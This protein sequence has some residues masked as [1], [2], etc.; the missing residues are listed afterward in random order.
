MK[1]RNNFFRYLT[2]IFSSAVYLNQL[3]V[4]SAVSDAETVTI[5]SDVYEVDVGDG[6]TA[7]HIKVDVSAGGTKATGT[8][9][10]DNTAPSDGETVTI[11]SKVYTF[12]TTLTPLEGEVLIN[13]TADAALLNLIRAINHSGTP[14]TDYQCAV[15]NPSVTAATSVTSHTFA[16][17]AIYTGLGGNSIAT[18]ET[19]AHLSWGATTLASAADPTAAQFIAAFVISVNAAGK[20]YT[21][22][23]I[24]GGVLVY[25]G[26]GVASS[27]LT[28]TETLAGS[29]NAWGAAAFYGGK[30]PAS[31][32]PKQVW[33]TRV[34]TATEVALTLMQVVV[35]F[36]PTV[37]T[38]D[39]VVTATG[40]RTAWDGA[41]TISGSIITLD[42]SVGSTHWATTSTVRIRAME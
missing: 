29:N 33:L 22:L 8:L 9:T 2:R 38:V 12:K 20:A 15:A 19:S 24:T 25:T 30:A 3:R 7:G 26:S 23:G 36:T 11:G 31:K 18:T 41:I 14:G 37:V 35:P 27:A 32:P 10:S 21:A 17:T 1:D 13:T 28:S 4:A 39:V 5:G 40:A 6:I 16:V 42:N 34:P